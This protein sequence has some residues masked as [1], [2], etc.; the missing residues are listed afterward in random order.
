MSYGGDF[1]RLVSENGPPMRR[2]EIPS[3]G[4]QRVVE[5]H[6][7]TVIALR[8]DRGILDVGDR[9]AT[10]ENV[11]MYDRADKIIPLDDYTL[12]AISGS[13]GR[14]MEVVRY[15]QHAFKYYRRSQLQEISIE[16]KVNEVSRAIA[17]NLPSALQG[18]GAFLPVLSVYDSRTLESRI[19]FYDA[20]GAKFESAE[21]GAAGSGSHRIRGV[22]DYIIKTKGHFR[23]MSLEEA[24]AEA[25]IML[26]IAAE[27]DA[28][29]AGYGKVPPVAKTV[30]AEGI[31]TLS[32]DYLRQVLTRLGK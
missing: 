26:D 29:T 23:E 5:A 24:L 1:L 21:F 20:L 32:E 19:F 25:L 17:G 2:G 9:R 6:G 15:L 18:L 31:N 11:V 13:Y 10:A 3:A 4:S 22:F 16:G 8:Y 14:A 12:L 27:L 30:S 28:F 7:T